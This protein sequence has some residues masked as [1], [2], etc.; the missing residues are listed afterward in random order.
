[1]C[2]SEEARIEALEKQIEEQ[3]KVFWKLVEILLKRKVID[4]DDEVTITEAA[5]LA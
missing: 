1:M 5:E 2:M 4:T 3:G